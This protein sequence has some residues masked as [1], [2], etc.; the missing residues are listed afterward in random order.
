MIYMACRGSAVRV[1][2]APSEFSLVI[3]ISSKKIYK[4]T[5]A[6]Y[7]CICAL[8]IKKNDNICN[9]E[10]KFLEIKHDV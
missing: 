8:Q 6:N 2:L 4:I 10:S 3:P 7:I 1:R 9:K 5:S